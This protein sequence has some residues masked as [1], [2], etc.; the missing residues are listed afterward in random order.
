[1]EKRILLCK[2]GIY[3]WSIILEDTDSFQHLELA[4]AANFRG[5][6]D[7][8]STFYQNFC[9][10]LAPDCFGAILT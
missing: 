4:L 10:F 9:S 6:L 1:M 2:A 5:R 3:Q 8:S 7:R